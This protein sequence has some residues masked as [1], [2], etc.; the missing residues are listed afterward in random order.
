MEKIQE[1]FIALCTTLVALSA[2]IV[3]KLW[4]RVDRLE[5]QLT[6]LNAERITKQDLDKIIN[7]QHLILQTLLSKKKD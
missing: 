2:W 5:D 6:K 1:W 3:K 7:V 4:G